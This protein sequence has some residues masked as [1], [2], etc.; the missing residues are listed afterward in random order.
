MYMTVTTQW[1]IPLPRMSY[2]ALYYTVCLVK[3]LQWNKRWLQTRSALCHCHL[4]AIA[5]LRAL[6][7]HSSL[8]CQLCV[9]PA[10]RRGSLLRLAALGIFQ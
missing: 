6:V 4:L 9:Q 1:R 2:G 10:K 8:S 5:N 3:R 7:A